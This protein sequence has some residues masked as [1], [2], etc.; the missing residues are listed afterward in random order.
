MTPEEIHHTEDASMDVAKLFA[1][2]VM[3]V[4]L[5]LALFRY[6]LGFALQYGGPLAMLAALAFG[7]IIVVY[8]S[9]VNFRIVRR[10]LSYRK[11]TE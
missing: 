1:G 5:L 10:M 8:L 7:L 11:D 2:V 9:I 4:I 3:V 6:G